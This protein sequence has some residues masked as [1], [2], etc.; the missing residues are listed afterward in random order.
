MMIY[1]KGG[2]GFGMNNKAIADKWMDNL[3]IWLSSINK[4]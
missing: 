1:P 2:H 3:K 4:L